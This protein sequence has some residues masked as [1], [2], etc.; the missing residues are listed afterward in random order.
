MDSKEKMDSQRWLNY[1]L[2]CAIIHVLTRIRRLNT[3]SI[4]DFEF[5]AQLLG[6]K[7]ALLKKLL[8]LLTGRLVTAP[9]P[10]ELKVFLRFNTHDVSIIKEIYLN[11]VYER[12][13]SPQFGDVVF[14]V[15]SHIGIFTLKASGRVGVAGCV[16]AFEPE[17]GNFR[18]L[19]LNLSLNNIQ[20]ARVFNTAVSSS[21]GTLILKVDHSNT[22]GNS[23]QLSSDWKKTSDLYEVVSSTTLDEIIEQNEVHKISFLK[24]DVEGHELEVLKGAERFLSICANIAMETHERGGGPRN[25][26]I[27]KVLEKSSFKTKLVLNPRFSDNDIIYG[28]K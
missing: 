19:R 3:N 13:Y 2:K 27:I 11:G 28:W 15:G 5:E 16:Y 20:N 24:L 10:G 7:T 8:F 22:G 18:I 6:L 21:S 1:S 25:S 26:E 9:L 4:V 12:F 23:V 14:D 17:I